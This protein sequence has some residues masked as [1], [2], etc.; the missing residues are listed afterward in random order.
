[1]LRKLMY[2]LVSGVC[3]ILL[4]FALSMSAAAQDTE[5]TAEEP[6]VVEVVEIDPAT[7]PAML[8]DVET[9]Q[10]NLDATWVLIAG[11]LVFFMQAG[12]AFLEAGMIQQVGVVNSM[13]ENFF[14]ALLTGV[15]FWAIG[16]GLAYGESNGI[17]GT[18]LFFYSGMNPDGSGLDAAYYISFFYQYA[19]AAAAGTIITGATAQRV[20]FWGKIVYTIII[21]AFIYPIVVHWVWSGTSGA[22][23]YNAG[24]RD[25][26]GSSVVHMV[27][28]ILALIGAI[29]VGP[30]LGRVWGNAPKGHNMV[31]ATLG[32]FILW[33]GWYGFNVG[34]TLNA[35]DPGLMGLVALN[36]TVA[37]A[38][39]S[40]LALFFAYIRS[41]KWDLPATLNGCLAGLVGIT[42]GCAYVSPGSAIIIG[43]LAGLI[44][45]W[46][47]ILLERFKI[48][49]AAGAFAVH[50]ACGAFGCIAIGFFGLP[51]LTG[52]EAGL[53]VGGGFSTVITQ[54][55]GVAVIAIYV[56]ITGTIMWTIL[57]V[58]GI[59]RI[60]AK[61]EAMGVD[62]YEHGQTAY[63][64]IIPMP[65]ES[66]TSVA[67]VRSAQ[68]AGD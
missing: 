66:A 20:N 10:V 49:D 32:T 54:V 41:G 52:N 64:D 22:F 26:A 44:V 19:F 43:A 60:P 63:P 14:D 23:L 34:S 45:Y 13:A 6:A 4:I 57:K 7:T 58:L 61:A 39:G 21:A 3:G 40:M 9:V 35:R 30:R 37:A 47:S 29:F 1:M 67:T 38:T 11:F 18:S 59:L 50:G 62:A 17:F 16:F 5:T 46:T 15:F 33:F 27:G 42:A 28:G 24:Y 2:K 31:L 36:T 25:F 65:T 51:V 12:F 55:V 68:A 48:D 8:S 53:L 56:T